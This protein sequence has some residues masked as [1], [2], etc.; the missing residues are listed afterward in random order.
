MAFT[1]TAGIPLPVSNGRRR[2]AETMTARGGWAGEGGRRL[3][4]GGAAGL[5]LL[6]LIAMQFTRQ[7][8]WGSEDFAIIGVMLAM[9]CGAYELAVRM[10]GSRAF[11]AAVLIAAM[12]CFLLIWVNLAVGIIGDE[13]NALNLVYLGVLAV[14]VC[15]AVLAWGRA[16]RMA[17][18]MV[19]AAVAQGAAGVVALANGYVTLP[20]EAFFIALWLLS[21][22]L[23]HEAG[24][25]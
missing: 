17:W 21:A 10:N 6:P 11:R 9:V 20:I 5:L 8:E 25:G 13:D 2:V 7:V 3:V 24:R 19:T 15:G 14:P 23:F 22:R 12:G 1:G 18:V 16:R 4:W